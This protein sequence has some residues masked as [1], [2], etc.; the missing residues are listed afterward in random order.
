MKYLIEQT[1]LLLGRGHNLLT[2]ETKNYLVRYL[3]NA[4]Y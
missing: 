2:Y 4:F 1:T 3:I